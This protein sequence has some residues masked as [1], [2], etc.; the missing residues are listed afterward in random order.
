MLG[1]GLCVAPPSA[2]PSGANYAWQR[3]SLYVISNDNLPKIRSGAVPKTRDVERRPR[4]REGERNAQLFRYCRQIV[5][6]C[7]DLDALID[8]ARSWADNECV[9][10]MP[11]AEVVKT[12][13]SVWKYQGRK[14]R[15]MQNVVEGPLYQR[16]IADP[17]VWA[18]YAYLA[19]EN[20][21][22]AQFMVADGLGPARGWPRRMVPK[23]RRAL[24][25]LGA[26]KCVRHPR[27]GTPGLYRW[28]A[29]LTPMRGGGGDI[30]LPTDSGMPFGG[31]S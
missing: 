23:A 30:G 28:P 14:R 26:I 11:D 13:A 8:A 22:A 2:R 6:Y 20:G 31:L 3:G 15:V 17:E 21:P 18:L 1:G 5:A 29:P 10:P 9:A 25:D 19:A 16:L 12:A 24:L 7:D 27:K 4:V